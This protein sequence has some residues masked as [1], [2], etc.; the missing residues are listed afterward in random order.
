MD[1]TCL[2][3]KDRD[4]RMASIDKGLDGNQ[5]KIV[6]SHDLASDTRLVQK[7]FAMCP[8][9]LQVSGGGGHG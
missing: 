2:L 4:V 1:P 9:S 6:W 8:Q 7:C 5:M 3:R